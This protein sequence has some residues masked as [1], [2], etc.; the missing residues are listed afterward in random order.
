MSLARKS[1]ARTLATVIAYVILIALL[2]F[3][4]APVALMI[5]TAFKPNVEIFQ[6]PPRWLPRAPTL[7]NFQK[8]MFNSGIPRYA[9]NSVIIAT[10][11]TFTA[12]VLGT[13]AGYGF[14]RFKFRGNRALSLFML[15]GQLIPLIALIVPFFQIF[16]AFGLLDTKIGIALAH[17]TTALPLVTWMSASYFSTIPVELDEAAI[18]DGCTR[19]QALRK[20]VLPVALPGIISI[21]LFAFLMSWNEFVLASVLTNTD[22]SKTLPIGLSEFATMFTVDWGSTMAAAFLMTVPVMAVFLV[23]QKQFVRGLSAGAV[24]G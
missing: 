18:I 16:D 21:A 1:N 9:L 14:S 20:V 17:L 2:F 15:L 8:V 11:M 4:L 6:V 10:L 24:K 5:G 19:M 22:N 7:S 12:L 3:A 23:F 13:M